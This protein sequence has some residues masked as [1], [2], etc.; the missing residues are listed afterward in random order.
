MA[1]TGSS[2]IG[3]MQPFDDTTETFTCYIERLELFFEANDITE[4]KKSALLSLIGPKTYNLLRGLTSPNKPKDKSYKEIIEILEG[5]LSPPPLEIAERYKFHKRN[6]LPG[7]SI[8]AF[9]AALK[10]M[11]EHCNFEGFIPQA[12]RDRFVCGLTNESI[13][14]K[15][16]CERD[17]TLEKAITIATAMEQ[18]GKDASSFHHTHSPPD[19]GA[20][21]P[22]STR[23]SQSR[24]F[25]VEQNPK[26]C[27][28]CGKT[29]H[30]RKDCR[31]LNATCRLCN[32]RGHIST[33]CMSA[34]NREKGV[35]SKPQTTHC[36]QEDE[37]SEG[38]ENEIQCLHVF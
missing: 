31:F 30:A 18:A 15:L 1:A 27:M 14:K 12:L 8:N 24:V 23:P 10:Q 28:S 17:L 20:Q 2:T 21:S 19:P 16:L 26:K 3:N 4:K 29:T 9:V 11:T 32:K 33:I 25:K 35:H 6:Q 13:Q 38:E 36:L 37:F 5:H 22:E 34:S 7:E